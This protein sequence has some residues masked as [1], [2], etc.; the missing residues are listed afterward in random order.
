M[1]RE[2]K[3]ERLARQAAE[4]AAAA[5][6]V[7][8]FRKTIPA[9]LVMMQAIANQVG[10]SCTV[11]LTETGPA[12][13]FDLNEYKNNRESTVID[14]TLRYD[15]DPWEVEYVET[16]LNDMKAEQEAKAAR[17]KMAQDH[18]NTLSPAMV[19]AIKENIYLLR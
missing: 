15:S 1:A 4:E 17:L 8:E 7:A 12:V 18:F 5:A 9:K 2:T 10:V 14:E 19:A 3:E 6:R 16:K 11:S 13:H